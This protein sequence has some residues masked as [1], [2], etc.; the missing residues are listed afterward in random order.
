VIV[1]FLINCPDQRQRA[2]RVLG[3]C[4]M[5]SLVRVNRAVIGFLVN[6]PANK[7]LILIHTPNDKT[8]AFITGGRRNI[9]LLH[10][11]TSPQSRFQQQS[12]R[13]GWLFS[14]NIT[15]F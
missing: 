8:D 4:E 5:P 9:L 2:K 11:Q 7:A 10:T 14:L 1:H 3:N 13:H 12:N 6:K 15:A